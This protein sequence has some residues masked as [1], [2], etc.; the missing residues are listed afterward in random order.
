[1]VIWVLVIML[2]GCT[3]QKRIYRPGYH[4]EWHKNYSNSN[5]SSQKNNMSSKKV[6]KQSNDKSEL[7]YLKMKFVNDS[8]FNYFVLE[9]K[10][11]NYHVNTENN[12]DELVIINQ[13]IQEDSLEAIKNK[14]VVENNIDN[15]HYLVKKTRL[16]FL[17]SFVFLYT[18]LGF[19]IF[20]TL[21]IFNGAKLYKLSR[22]N[23]IYYE[24]QNKAEE[25]LLGAF[26]ILF[27][28]FSFI[29]Y[30]LFFFTSYIFLVPSILFFII[31][32]I[33][34]IIMF[35]GDKKSKFKSNKKEY[36]KNNLNKNLNKR[37]IVIIFFSLSLFLL[38]LILGIT[39]Q[40][41]FLAFSF[42]SLISFIL[43]LKIYFSILRNNNLKKYDYKFLRKIRILLISIFLLSF[44]IF[45][46]L[47]Q[48]EIVYLVLIAI[49]F[50]LPYFI[51]LLT[52][53]IKLINNLKLN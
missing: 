50:Y 44:L 24:N 20:I 5:K 42:L 33:G 30:I 6:E 13:P 18:G 15:T 37:W 53:I 52:E 25:S 41:F 35:S 4:I 7:S 10:T 2:T 16:F 36:L 31:L 47:L 40:F 12:K 1:M 9:E 21:T 39:L 34:L 43:S 38:F 19:I 49:V 23:G 3:V 27:V 14:N 32:L 48:I 8:I 17:L 29:T 11:S 51:I 22:E 46:F 45:L 26:L 28:L